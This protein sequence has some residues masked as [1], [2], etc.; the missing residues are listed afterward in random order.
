MQSSASDAERNFEAFTD[1]IPPKETPVT[2]ELIPIP[3]A[4][5][6]PPDEK[7]RDEK[8]PDKK[9]PDKK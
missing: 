2:I 7:S 6:K 3:A 9:S 8:S 4:A 5:A 1:R